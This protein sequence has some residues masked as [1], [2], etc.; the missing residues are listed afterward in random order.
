MGVGI[1]VWFRSGPSL[2]PVV[3]TLNDP[4]LPV[5][6]F[7]PVRSAAKPGLGF[8]AD[9]YGFSIF[10]AF[11]ASDVESFREKTKALG[12]EGLCVLNFRQTIDELLVPEDPFS[13]FW[14]DN[15][16]VQHA[17]QTAESAENMLRMIEGGRW[18]ELQH[19]VTRMERWKLDGYYLGVAV[20]EA[21]FIEAVVDELTKIAGHCRWFAANRTQ[22]VLVSVAT[23]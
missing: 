20:S 5:D 9:S 10:R 13:P 22:P 6:R 12:L 19:F 18:D 3:E 21:E 2:D 1:E 4:A 8:P 16:D 17:E 7:R 11:Q 15:V 14:I 23:I